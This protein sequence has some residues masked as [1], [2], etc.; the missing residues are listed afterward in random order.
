MLAMSAGASGLLAA[1]KTCMYCGIFKLLSDTGRALSQEVPVDVN[2][3]ACRRRGGGRAGAPSSSSPLSATAA[4]AGTA[5][6]V[7]GRAGRRTSSDATLRPNY[8]V[9]HQR[10]GSTTST[11]SRADST[12]RAPQRSTTTPAQRPPTT[13][14]TTATSAPLKQ[15]QQSLPTGTGTGSRSFQAPPPPP[16]RPN[17]PHLPA[18]ARRV[19]SS[20]SSSSISPA[21][22]FHTLARPGSG[23]P[24][25]PDLMP[26][27]PTPSFG[28]PRVAS[29]DASFAHI[30]TPG[31]SPSLSPAIVPASASAAA[32]QSQSQSSQPNLE[33]LTHQ[34]AR[35]KQQWHATHDDHSHDASQPTPTQRATMEAC[36]AKIEKMYRAYVASGG[37]VAPAAHADDM[38]LPHGI[39]TDKRIERIRNGREPERLPVDVSVRQALGP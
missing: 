24:H 27:S 14:T 37:P 11:A 9:E 20:S 5:A 21:S 31:A 29:P 1:G 34:Y 39:C 38:Q 28:L 17:A 19:S 22:A 26:S 10:H 33:T 30:M 13:T 3:D 6:G 23:S 2:C 16:L 8:G 12:L 32:A 35:S 18:L 36:D 7:D 25:T 15:R 4:A